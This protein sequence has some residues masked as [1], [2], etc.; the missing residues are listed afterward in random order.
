M[1]QA[2][3]GLQSLMAR[4]LQSLPE[5]ERVLAAWPMVCGKAVAQRTHALDFTNG[6]LRVAVSDRSWEQLRSLA[7][8]YLEQLRAQSG[9]TVN[10]ILFV[11]PDDARPDRTHDRNTDRNRNHSK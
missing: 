5:H 10:D 7:P 3:R 2:A 8:Q 6:T 1:E 11:H 9:I 4:L